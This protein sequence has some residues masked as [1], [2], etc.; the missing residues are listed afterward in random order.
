M[1]N[2]QH[3]IHGKK[4]RSKS[5]ARRLHGLCRGAPRLKEEAS[6]HRVWKGM[7]VMATGV[8]VSKA[9]TIACVPSFRVAGAPDAVNHE[10]KLG[11]KG[12][13]ALEVCAV[14]GAV[15]GA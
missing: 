11:G 3:P 15:S 9:A 2:I 13:E 4:K 12:R 7:R 5:I 1:Y 6:A 8:P 10:A 14:R